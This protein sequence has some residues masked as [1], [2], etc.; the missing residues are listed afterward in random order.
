MPHETSAPVVRFRD[1]SVGDAERAELLEVIDGLLRGGQLILGPDVEA[2]EQEFAR[3]CQ[4]SECVGVS[5]GT[6]GLYLALRALGVG[7][8]DEVVT[9]AMSWVATANAVI[10]L[11]ATPVFA[12]VADDFNID[13][14]PLHLQKP[15]RE[16][17]YGPGDMPVAEAQA[18]RLITLPA[19]EYLTDEQVEFTCGVVTA[20][21]SLT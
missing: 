17:G 8:G 20:Y 13:P 14:V 21:S 15:G 11:G 1:L 9:T 19:H 10:A 2:F 6:A 18:G 3:Q 16:L 4:R 5:N 12:D 7:P